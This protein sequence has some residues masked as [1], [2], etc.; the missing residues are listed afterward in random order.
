MESRRQVRAHIGYRILKDSMVSS[1]IT[2]SVQI[3]VLEVATRTENSFQN[4]LAEIVT[5]Q[6]LRVAMEIQRLLTN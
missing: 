1:L 2:S 5:K 6:H 4:L 3:L